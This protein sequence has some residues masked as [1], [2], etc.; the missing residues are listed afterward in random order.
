MYVYF[1]QKQTLLGERE[2]PKEL[3]IAKFA[4]RICFNQ[5]VTNS[6]TRDIFSLL[7]KP[8]ILF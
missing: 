6:H 4:S 7:A 3:Q 8:A 5:R 2:S 1:E